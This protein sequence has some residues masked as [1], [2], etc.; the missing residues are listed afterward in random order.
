M[1]IIE[2]GICMYTYKGLPVWISF[3][4]AY[5]SFSKAYDSLLLNDVYYVY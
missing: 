2:S 1:Y 5:D 3:S 4:K